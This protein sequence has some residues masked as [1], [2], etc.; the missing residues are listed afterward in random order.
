MIVN[1]D[2]LQEEKSLDKRSSFVLPSSEVI[3]ALTKGRK[4]IL[5]LVSL[6]KEVRMTSVLKRGPK[7]G[8]P[9]GNV[10]C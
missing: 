7:K 1:I 10:H 2:I 3:S 6:G 5:Q 4:I 8:K 9:Q